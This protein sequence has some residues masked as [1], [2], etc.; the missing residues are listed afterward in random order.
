VAPATGEGIP[1]SIKD[2]VTDGL[3]QGI[4]KSRQYRAVVGMGKWLVWELRQ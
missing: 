2:G 4:V 3:M 1:Q